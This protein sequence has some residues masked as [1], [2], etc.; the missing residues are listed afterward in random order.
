M[1][2]KVAGC[3][4]TQTVSHRSLTMEAGFNPRLMHV[5]LVVEKV[6]NNKGFLQVI[7]LSFVRI[8]SPTIHPSWMLYNLNICPI[9]SKHTHTHTQTFHFWGC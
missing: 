6:A 5:G 8:I 7:Q 9:I 4:K 1:D 3:A 2:T